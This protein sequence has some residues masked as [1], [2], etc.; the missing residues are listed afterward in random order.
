[1]RPGYGKALRRPKPGGG[2]AVRPHF[3]HR[4]Y[5]NTLAPLLEDPWRWVKLVIGAVFLLGQAIAVRRSP[6]TS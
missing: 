5:I 2:K 6:I 1:M 4:F 3:W